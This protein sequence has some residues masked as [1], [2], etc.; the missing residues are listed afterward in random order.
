[1]SKICMRLFQKQRFS[2]V[3]KAHIVYVGDI[4]PTPKLSWYGDLAVRQLT[5][6]LYEAGKLSLRD[7]P[8]KKFLI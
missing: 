4:Y 6:Q 2:Y 8:T 3:N 5:H 1:M 7:S